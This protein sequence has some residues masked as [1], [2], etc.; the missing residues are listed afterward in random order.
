MHKTLVVTA[1]NRRLY[2]EYAHRFH[3]TFPHQHLDLAVVSED[4]APHT[5]HELTAHQAFAEKNKHR[6]VKGFK[7]DAVRFCHKP[8]SIWTVLERIPRKYTRLLWIDADTVF[9]KEID[10]SWI[11]QHLYNEHSLMT[12]MGRPQYHSETGVL[13]FNLEHEQA[14][15]YVNTVVELYNTNKVY[16]LRETHDSYVWDWCRQKFE[17]EGTQFNNVGV[18]YRVPGGHI[19][20]YLYGEWFDHTKGSKRKRLGKSPENRQK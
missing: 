7:H 17:H 13:L 15:D 1:Y 12:Y 9:R 6:P 5:T 11:T 4:N 3:S 20:V 19:Q 18:D 2:S 10:E 8:Y 14:R 16:E